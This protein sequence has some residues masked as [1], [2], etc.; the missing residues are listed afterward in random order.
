MSSLV[1]SVG[2]C[3]FRTIILH[4]WPLH[5]R[6]GI[7]S[8]TNCILLTADMI[9]L[10]TRKP[11]PNFELR[12]LLHRKMGD[13]LP[14]QCHPSPIWHPVHP[15]SLTYTFPTPLLPFLMNCLIEAP[16]MPRSKPH[17]L[18][19]VLRSC[20]RIHPGPTVCRILRNNFLGVG[21]CYLPA[22]SPS[23]KATPFRLSATAYSIY[24]QLPSISGGRLLHPQ[25]E[26]APCRGDKGSN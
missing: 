5:V 3:T 1:S 15:L 4:R 19:P 7:L 26:G 24:W 25:L 13:S 16:N 12:S 10:C 2:A 17:V 6:Y 18:F 8:Q 14:V 22:Q 11:L 9:H 23:W 20:Q 21:I